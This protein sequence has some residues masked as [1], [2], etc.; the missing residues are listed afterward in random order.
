MINV[1]LPG[2]LFQEIVV[3][4]YKRK[5]TMKNEITLSI[6]DSTPRITQTSLDVNA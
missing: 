5:A 1:H 2:L 6:I 4:T 3:I